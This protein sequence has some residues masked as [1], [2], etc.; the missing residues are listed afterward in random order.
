[1]K[2]VL[3]IATFVVALTVGGQAI[4]WHDCGSPMVAYP[5]PAYAG[6]AR[7]SAYPPIAPR[8][9]Y[10]PAPPVRRYPVHYGGHDHHHNYRNNGVTISF[11][12]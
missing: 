11:G 7:Y 1:M 2:R 8:V 12:F 3:L 4:A 5:Y 10:Y 6:Y 9:A